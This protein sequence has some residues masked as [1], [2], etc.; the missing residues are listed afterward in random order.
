MKR[1]SPESSPP[2]RYFVPEGLPSPDELDSMPPK[3]LLKRLNLHARKGFS[4]SFLTDSYVVS[5]IL[6]AAGLQPDDQVLEI[7]PGLGVLTRGLV[8]R[9]G[10]VVA[11]EFDPILAE[12]LPRLVSLPERLEL[13][14]SD[15]LEFDLASTLR[16]AYKVVANLPYHITSPVL[17]MLL[18]ASNKPRLMVVMVQKEV[19]D[20][21]MAKPG[22]TSLL[23]IMVQLYSRVS[24]VTQVPAGSFFPAPKVDSTVLKLEVYEK[25][26]LDV[27]DPEAML[28]IVAAGFS[29]RRKQ[30]HNSLSEGLWF[31]AGGVMELLSDAGIDPSRRAQT[32]TL[33]EWAQ[34]Y[35]C[36]QKLKDQWQREGVS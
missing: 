4:Q 10:R 8:K 36:Y 12:L 27:D 35:R 20:R 34:L 3:A 32:L 9:V 33:E 19:A 25:L 15:I 24:V 30:L 13:Y 18:T 14:H 11:V 22:D 6:D 7:G 26:P 31:P 16:G 21:V 2:T 5:A 29:R 17:R 1:G 28:K 23:S